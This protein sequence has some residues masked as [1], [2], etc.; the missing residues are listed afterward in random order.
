MLDEPGDVVRDPARHTT[1]AHEYAELHVEAQ[2]IRRQV[3]A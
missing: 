3:G 2:G 1:A